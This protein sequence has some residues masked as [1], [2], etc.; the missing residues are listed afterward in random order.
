MQV[1]Y[2]YGFHGRQP[3][4]D[5]YPASG[6]C[7][8]FH[9]SGVPSHCSGLSSPRLPSCRSLYQTTP[10][11]V[12]LTASGAQAAT[13]RVHLVCSAWRFNFFTK[14][15]V[16]NHPL[17]NVIVLKSIIMYVL[18]QAQARTGLTP[19]GCALDFPISQGGSS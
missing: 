9:F 18:V 11:P 5:S 10:Y 2:Y 15:L 13:P 14:I 19:H 3:K 6:S 8:F 17:F 1:V 7:C 4:M 12:S 16:R